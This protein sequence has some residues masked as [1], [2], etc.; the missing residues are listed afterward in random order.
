MDEQDAP[1]R[2]STERPL[3]P[4][5]LRS[6]CWRCA[7]CWRCSVAASATALRFSLSRSPKSFGW[8][9]AQVVSVYS[10]TWLAG[11]LMAPRDRPAVRPLRARLIYSLGLLL[12]GGAFLGG[13]ARAGAVAVPVRASDSCVGIGIAL[14]GNV[15]NSILLGRVVRPRAADQ[16]WRFL[17]SAT[18]A[19]ILV[20]LPASQLLIDHVG[21]RGA[22]QLF[23]IIS[24]LPA[25]AAAA[26]AVAAVRHPARCLSP[27]RPTPDFVDERLD[28]R[29]SAMRHHTFWALFSTFFFTAVGDVRAFGTDR[30]LPD[31]RRISAI[32]G[33]HRLGLFRHRPVVRH[34]RHIPRWTA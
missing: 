12:L 26:A 9:R 14:V 6:A 24:T 22:Y 2:T 34:A 10:L 29:T 16:R 19:G 27:R 21:W 30:R 8:D 20:L 28:A 25:G 31:R 23:G 32:A 33:R 11:G 5:A 3:K 4:G 15:P 13:L 18:G 7:S 1:G 17:Y